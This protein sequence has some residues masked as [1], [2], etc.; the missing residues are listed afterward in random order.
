MS[1]KAKNAGAPKGGNREDFGPRPVPKNGA[2]K[3]RVSLIVDLGEQNREDFEDESS[4][5]KR[6]QKPCQQVAVF[7]DLVQDVVDYG[8]SIG[9]AQYRLM[10]NKDFGGEVTGINHVLTPPKDNKGN[11][12]KDKPWSFHPRNR[13]TELCKATGMP[14]I[15]LDA[16]AENPDGTDISLLLGLPL[17]ADVE[18]SEKDSGKV[19]KD[20][21]PIIYKNVRFKGASQVPMIETDDLDGDG[22]AIEMP[23]P[24]ADL[25]SQ[26]RCIMFDTATVE[27]IKFIRSNLIRKIKLANNYAGSNMQK[28]IEAFEAAQGSSA[29]DDDGSG[30]PES[31][32]APR[33]RVTPPKAGKTSGKPAA[34]KKPVPK[35]DGEDDDV[36]F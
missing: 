32:A 18:V 16:S 11:I 29:S 30:E 21:N 22:N 35:P 7:V 1:F 15:A 26:A 25:K 9:K 28:A 33:E 36:P 23:A 6:T 5:E 27:D 19:D 34:E 4:G 14:H 10:V 2:R 13:L 24:V 20:K 17:I 3:G 31:Q 12:L 8:G